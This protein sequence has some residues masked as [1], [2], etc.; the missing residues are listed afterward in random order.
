MCNLNIGNV[1][2]TPLKHIEYGL[3]RSLPAAVTKIVVNQILRYDYSAEWPAL[4]AECQR[5]FD[6][7]TVKLP[8]LQAAYDEAVRELEMP[9]DHYSDPKNSEEV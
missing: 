4:K 1:Y 7:L 6:E 3:L 5:E 9:L 8:E 2:D